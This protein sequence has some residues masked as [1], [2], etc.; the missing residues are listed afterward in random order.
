MK[1][2]IALMTFLVGI[3][4]AASINW[5]DYSDNAFSQAQKQG[6]KVVLGFH[7][8]GCATCHAQA[9]VLEATGLDQYKK[10]SFLR[11]TY[12]KA[13]HEEIFKRYKVK[14]WAV[15]LM[16][17]EKGDKIPGARV[18]PFDTGLKALSKFSSYA[19]V[20]LRNNIVGF[21]Y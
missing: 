11:L 18:G 20:K 8:K 3:N 4:A 5:V 12:G 10:M 6:K 7:K 9:D 16:L 21:K 17:D 13:E 1:N 2:F 14:K 15:L 19:K